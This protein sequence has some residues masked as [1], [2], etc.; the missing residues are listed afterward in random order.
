MAIMAINETNGRSS[1][2]GCSF[3]AGE[4]FAGR[5]SAVPTL[6]KRDTTLGLVDQGSFHVSTV[7]AGSIL[8]SFLERGSTLGMVSL[9]AESYGAINPTTWEFTLRGGITFPNGTP[10]DACPVK[11]SLDRLVDPPIKAKQ[12]PS[13]KWIAPVEVR[14]PSTVRVVARDPY[15]TLDAQLAV[16]VNIVPPCSF[17]EHDAAHVARNPVGTGPYAF[18]HWR[19]DEEFL[20]EA[21]AACRRG[22]PGARPWCS[23][24]CGKPPRG[25][26]G[27]NPAGWTAR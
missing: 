8:E 23:N 24:P 16:R 2:K 12:V 20:L 15:P 22:A 25:V 1:C 26:P 9:L 19:K 7:A 14:G 11:V 27:C 18:V 5:P 3:N 13:F 10:T 21:N 17:R 4:A 6:S